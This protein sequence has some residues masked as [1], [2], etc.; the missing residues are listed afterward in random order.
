M[1]SC[2]VRWR[3]IHHTG[4]Y[5]V[6]N[7]WSGAYNISRHD[8]A[9]LTS[10][11]LLRHKD[12]VG[13]GPCSDIPDY[14]HS[15]TSSPSRPSRASSYDLLC[16]GIESTTYYSQPRWRQTRLVEPLAFDSNTSTST[17][18]T[19]LHDHSPTG[20]SCHA[21][22]V[23]FATMIWKVQTRWGMDWGSTEYSVS[24]SMSQW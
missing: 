1:V 6:R 23:L 17:S 7:N 16:V 14:L 8:Q 24:R 10:S 2:S 21:S 11:Q 15:E 13:S 20:R 22:T 18:S 3:E 5:A 9:Q 19:W 12:F 4:C